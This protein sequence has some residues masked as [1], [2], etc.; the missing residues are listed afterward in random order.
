[1]SK[2]NPLLPLEYCRIDRAARLLKC[3][4]DDILHWGA[5]SKISLRILAEH[6]PFG[7]PP[8]SSDVSSKAPVLYTGPEYPE[9]D[10]IFEQGGHF[11]VS[12]YAS[13]SIDPVEEKAGTAGAF[14]FR[15]CV[16][17]IKGIWRVPSPV[18]ARIYHGT[19]NNP[20][21]IYE[22]YLRKSRSQVISNGFFTVLGYICGQ[23]DFA[24]VK[25]Q[26]IIMADDLTL[27]HKHITSGEPI[28][29]NNGVV[30]ADSKVMCASSTETKTRVTA[31]QSKAIVELLTTHGLKAEDFRGSIE[32]LK[33]KIASKG[34][35]KTLVNV[36]K[37]TLTDW[38]KKANVR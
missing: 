32:A 13:L 34:L 1:M 9:V 8:D 10:S 3:E 25:N 6:R 30:T 36:D 15:L 14:S 21:P 26:L 27:L 24:R 33:Q 23:Q 11:P 19:G 4:V 22:P 16:A 17:D 28:P 12:E 35:S 7:C 37:N 5:T 18:I 2:D 20:F 38:L 31:N 29:I